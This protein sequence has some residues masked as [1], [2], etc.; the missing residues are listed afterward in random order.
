MASSPRGTPIP[1]RRRP[2]S[3]G[4]AGTRAQGGSTVGGVGMRDGSRQGRKAGLEDTLAQAG[5]DGHCCLPEPNLIREA[6]RILEVG[7]E[8]TGLCLDELAADEGV[9]REPV[10]ASD[11]ATGRTVPAVYL[12]PFHRAECS[13]AGG[14][15]D[16]LCSG[17]DRLPAFARGDCP[18]APGWPRGPSR[19]RLAPQH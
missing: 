18:H 9:V 4:S 16:L 15:M 2:P 13:L 6:A 17:P 11:D 7:R 3:R 8:L 10:P 19:L 5:E 12:V 1:P 14:L